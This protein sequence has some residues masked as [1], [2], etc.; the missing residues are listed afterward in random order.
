MNPTLQKTLRFP[1]I[2]PDTVNRTSDYRL[3]AS[4]KGI[5]VSRVLTQLGKK[6]LHLTQL[7]GALRPLFLELCNEDGLA[8]TW[9]ESDSS[10]RFA[11]TLINSADSSVT[12]LVEEPEPVA[13]GTEERFMNAIVAALPAHEY[14]IISGTKAAGFSD[15]LVPF[16]VRRAKEE[17]VKTII[18]VKGKDLINSLPF[19]PD[20]VKP[21]LYEFACTFAPEMVERNDL[22][23]DENKV[24]QRITELV[25]D[26]SAKYKCRI[27]LTRGAKKIW[28]SEKQNFFEVD[29]NPVKPVNTIGS[30][31]AFTAGLAAALGDGAALREAIAE[32]VRC[33]SLN[34]QCFKVGVIRE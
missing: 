31:D 16:M 7:G 22:L 10:I 3:D 17:G 30:G 4:G 24:R 2:I 15:N 13:P 34:A 1:D 12:E 28:A 23:G 11:Y 32:G 26:L 5:N 25:L 27:I 33:G 8:L 19:E 21:N 6:A 29:L 14:L 9:V 18:D 20:I